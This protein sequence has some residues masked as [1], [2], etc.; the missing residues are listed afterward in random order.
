MHLSLET[1]LNQ[2]QTEPQTIKFDDTIAVIKRYYHVKPCA[3]RNGD[4]DN[5]VGENKGSC[6]L[7]AFAHLHNLSESQTL[8]CFGDY[9]REEVLGDL[10]GDSHQNIRQFMKYGWD[11]VEFSD[12][13]LVEKTAIQD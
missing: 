8:A 7:L 3:F 9:Y 2:L 1:F 6:Q 4:I 11:G 10:L 13:V 5:Q 12:A